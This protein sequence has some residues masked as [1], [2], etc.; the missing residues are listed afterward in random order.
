MKGL[1]KFMVFVALVF[2]VPLLLYATKMS[3]NIVYADT[4]KD[5]M[6]F[7]IT[8]DSM[9]TIN[10]LGD[11]GAT[12][13][14]GDVSLETS[15]C[16]YSNI[17]TDSPSTSYMYD[18]MGDGDNDTDYSGEFRLHSNTT[19][20]YIVYRAFWKD[21]YQGY[22][23]FF[24]E[25]WVGDADWIAD[26]VSRT[27]DDVGGFNGFLNITISAA[28]IAGADAGDYSDTLVLNVKPYGS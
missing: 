26:K 18:I 28:A 11:M 25:A 27:C 16:L 3:N 13:P 8:V 5:S 14:I 20:D 10:G 9:L 7:T 6:E 23:E 15:A 21:E 17:S 19:G 22:Q 24:P 1:F 4:D 12:D 2:C